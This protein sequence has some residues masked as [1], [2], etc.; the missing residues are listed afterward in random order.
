MEI[1]L[2]GLKHNSWLDGL[3][4]GGLC[5][6]ASMA[7]SGAWP[8]RGY[9]QSSWFPWKVA[10]LVLDMSD[11]GGCTEGTRSSVEKKKVGSKF[12]YAICRDIITSGN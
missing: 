7:G 3:G 2:L 10:I 4:I 1:Q 8:G 6:T 5:D 9:R 11:G 12:Q